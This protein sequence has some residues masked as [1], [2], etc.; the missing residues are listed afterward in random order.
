MVKEGGHNI[1]TLTIQSESVQDDHPP[2]KIFF[3]NSQRHKMK[4]KLR[5]FKT[6]F[7]ATTTT[8]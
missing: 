7:I 1:G 2:K 4:K 6:N 3:E 5:T 8:H